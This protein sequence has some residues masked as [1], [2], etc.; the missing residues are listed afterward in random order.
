MAMVSPTIRA[1]TTARFLPLSLSPC[2]IGFS[3]WSCWAAYFAHLGTLPSRPSGERVELLA[4]A[5]P[6]LFACHDE[7]LL[8]QNPQVNTRGQLHSGTSEIFLP[9]KCWIALYYKIGY[10]PGMDSAKLAQAVVE[11]M[12]PRVERMGVSKMRSLTSS[13]I[14]RMK[15]PIFVEAPHKRTPIAVVVKYEDYLK[16][17]NVLF[18]VE[19]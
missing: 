15:G 17:Q 13:A 1:R 3:C 19:E 14:N 5:V 4:L 18:E 2:H 12:K 10:N 6:S 8:S 9:L 11:M 7:S 16:V